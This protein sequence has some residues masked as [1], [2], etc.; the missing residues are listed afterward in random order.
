MP[1]MP[2]MPGGPRAP[3]PTNKPPKKPRGFRV[4]NRLFRD[5][6]EAIRYM[7][8]N[9]GWVGKRYGQLVV[10]KRGKLLQD[11]G[12]SLDR[13]G[14]KY[15]LR[16][17]SIGVGPDQRRN[18][19]PKN[20]NL[21]TY[22]RDPVALARGDGSK[23]VVVGGPNAPGTGGPSVDPNKPTTKPTK[24]GRSVTGA[25]A[26]SKAQEEAD[27]YA[28]VAALFQGLQ[29]GNVGQ[30]IDEQDILS[31]LGN[32]ESSAQS[33]LAQQLS[34]LDRQK[35]WNTNAIQ[36]W[37][38]QVGRGV[39]TARTRNQEMTGD[40]SS[41][42]SGNVQGILESVGGSAALGAGPI[43]AAGASGVNT[44]TAIGAADAQYLNDMQPLLQ[45]EGA[46]AS[47]QETRRLGQ[48]GQ[49][50]RQSMQQLG[51]EGDDKR[52]TL[53][54]QIRQQ[55]NALKQ[56]QYSNKVSIA[57]ALASLMLS[58][59]QMTAQQQKAI[60]DQYQAQNA[61][62][63]RAGN[64]AANRGL[65]GAIAQEKS[66]AAKYAA[67]VGSLPSM[68]DLQAEGIAPAGE[69]GNASPELVAKVLAI[70]RE[71]G[72]DTSDPRVKKRVKASIEA[73]GGRVPYAWPRNW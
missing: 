26:G 29:G 20:P 71:A 66:E 32:T 45:A 5:R 4:N 60:I 64:D 21:W 16:N 2:P 19:K 15:V 41:A 42:L 31:Q 33:I 57:E 23:P 56:Q 54:L 1:G 52:A 22:A 53:A 13:W 44:L 70:Y 18:R 24:P 7:R 11:A 43:G 10:G 69:D 34:S 35:K 63:Y 62:G 3:R 28:R 27:F 37:Y 39:D 8:A 40:L 59:E 68:E 38:G 55:N 49:E 25:G 72:L 58:G 36:N 51:A 30:P 9:P 47:V 46:N 50:L 61:L 6:N 48:M 73:Y 14:G 12:F 17:R 67:A 65:R